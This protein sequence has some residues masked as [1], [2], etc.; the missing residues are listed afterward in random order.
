V[1]SK[2]RH[3]WSPGIID[4]PLV[5]DRAIDAAIGLRQESRTLATFAALRSRL[6]LTASVRRD[7]AWKFGARG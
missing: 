3:A 1:R 4:G 2:S 7:G 5:F 6:A